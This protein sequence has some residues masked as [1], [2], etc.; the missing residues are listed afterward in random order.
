M[1]IVGEYVLRIPLSQVDVISYFLGSAGLNPAE[2][3]SLISAALHCM[4][5]NVAP[6]GL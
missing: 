6:D 2:S 1:V 4:A 5:A 3:G